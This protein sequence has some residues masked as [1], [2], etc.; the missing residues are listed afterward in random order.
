MKEYVKP[1]VTIQGFV[2]R[3]DISVSLDDWLASMQGQ[4]FQDAGISTYSLSSLSE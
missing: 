4:G 1:T 2:S 3:E